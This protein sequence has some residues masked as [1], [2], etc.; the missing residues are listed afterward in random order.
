M[1]MTY[2]SADIAAVKGIV[3]IHAHTILP[4]TPQRTAVKRL[5]DPTPI[6]EPV[7]VCVVLTGTPKA[8]AT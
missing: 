1:H 4:A 7:I 2:I 6:I 5:K 3:R 8:D